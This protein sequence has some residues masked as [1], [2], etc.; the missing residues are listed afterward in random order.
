MARRSLRTARHEAGHAVVG[1]LLGLVIKRLAINPDG[2]GGH[3]EW[4]YRL[5]NSPREAAFVIGP[6]M[7][8][9]V[10]AE[11]LWRHIPK[12]CYYKNSSDSATLKALGGRVWP[13]LILAES[14]VE[15]RRG[16]IDRIAKE[17]VKRD[18]SRKDFLRFVCP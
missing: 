14:L 16:L 17:L 10:A 6:F 7:M 12:H 18:L 3:C 13:A 5:K 9:G 1:H 11:A 4:E 2:S 15:P 8:A